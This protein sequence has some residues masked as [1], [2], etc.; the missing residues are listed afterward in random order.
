MKPGSKR[1]LRRCPRRPKRFQPLDFQSTVKTRFPIPVTSFPTRLDPSFLL[2]LHSP[3]RYR[4]S[5]LS[6]SPLPLR[7]RALPLRATVP[8]HPRSL[9]RFFLPL[10]AAAHSAHPLRRHRFVQGFLAFVALGFVFFTR[11][12]PEKC[13]FPLHF[14][15]EVVY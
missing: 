14:R 6:L 3:P 11:I 15:L 8:S 4:L 5:S 7:P 2:P 9:R 13:P 12:H 1:S 10:T